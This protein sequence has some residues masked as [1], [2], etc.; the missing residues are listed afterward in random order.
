M[1][2]S[3]TRRNHPVEDR[4]LGLDG[5]TTGFAGQHTERF[6]EALQTYHQIGIAV[7]LQQRSGGAHPLLI[8]N[9]LGVD[10]QVGVECQRTSRCKERASPLAGWDARLVSRARRVAVLGLSRQ[11]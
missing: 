8:T 2:R 3:C 1:L 11:A 4:A 6:T 10:Q 9:A 5:R 7:W